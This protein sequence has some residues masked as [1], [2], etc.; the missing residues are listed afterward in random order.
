MS[1]PT[2]SDP[3]RKLH[4]L[5]AKRTRLLGEINIA[6]GV[7]TERDYANYQRLMRAIGKPPL[8]DGDPEWFPDYKAML[9]ERLVAIENEAEVYRGQCREDRTDSWYMPRMRR[10]TK[11]V[12]AVLAL[13]ASAGGG[14]A[15]NESSRG[16]ESERIAVLEAGVA[17]MRQDIRE[18]RQL[19]QTMRSVSANS[20][21]GRAYTSNPIRTNVIQTASGVPT[22]KQGG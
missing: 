14:V 4:E 19:V 3:C 20:I 17:E 12:A 11:P 6:N 2:I 10:L 13:F 22:G 9:N 16:S 15:V 21:P 7:G 5:D 1:T 8:D 18:L